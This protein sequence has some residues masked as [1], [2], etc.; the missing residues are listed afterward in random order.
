[1]GHI[2]YTKWDT[3]K[4]VPKL[5]TEAG[6]NSGAHLLSKSGPVGCKG[7]ENDP[8]VGHINYIKWGTT[9]YVLQ[10]GTFTI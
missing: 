6:H 3:T 9:K 8:K 10:W 1:M 7:E 2:Y 4:Y 5:G